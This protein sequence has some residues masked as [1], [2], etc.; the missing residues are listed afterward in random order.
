MQNKEAAIALQQ[1]DKEAAIVLQHEADLANMKKQC[2]E[3][4]A[5]LHA[6]LNAS[7][8]KYQ[9]LYSRQILFCPPTKIC[10]NVLKQ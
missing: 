10:L 8:R 4:T 5:T 7:K 2:D 3:A 1:K 6:D 9:Q